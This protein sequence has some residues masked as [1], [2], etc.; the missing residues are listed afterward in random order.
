MNRTALVWKYFFQQKWEEISW[1]FEEY[2]S[3]YFGISLFF[4]VMFQ[5]GWIG[6]QEYYSD[7]YDPLN[8]LLGK[9][10]LVI[11]AFWIIVGLIIVLK[12]F[13]G[14]IHDNWKRANERADKEIKKHKRGRK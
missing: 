3:A 2:G 4:A 14:W 10:G 9:I 7:V 6:T 11:I 8:P 1:H 5:I 12:I 13:C